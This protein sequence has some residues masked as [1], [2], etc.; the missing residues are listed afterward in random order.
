MPTDGPNY[1]SIAV[2]QHKRPEDYD[3]LERRSEIYNL[4][5]EAGSP[6]AI[7][8]QKQ[9]ADYYDVAES[10]ISK[11]MK[12]L[13]EFI[14]ETEGEGV[15]FDTRVRFEKTVQ[16]LQKEGKWKQAWDVTMEYNEW[17]ADAGFISLEPKQVE[18]S[19]EENRATDGYEIIT[20]DSEAADATDQ[21]QSPPEQLQDSTATLTLPVI[22]DDETP[23]VETDG[24]Q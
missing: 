20:V 5:R 22:D 9:L 14:M 24:E 15:A 7:A 2:P 6:H 4:I 19:I 23:D 3:Y 18:M 12:R 13:K 10:T 21:S 17:L 11:D 16:E 1:R 8:P